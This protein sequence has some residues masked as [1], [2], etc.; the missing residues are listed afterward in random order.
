MHLQSRSIFQAAM[1]VC[2]NVTC[3][4]R[5]AGTV[6]LQGSNISHQTGKGKSST[7]ICQTSGGHVSSL[8]GNPRVF[9]AAPPF[10]H[11]SYQKARLAPQTDGHIATSGRWKSVPQGYLKRQR[12]SWYHGKSRNQLWLRRYTTLNCWLLGNFHFLA[13]MIWKM[14]SEL[15]KGYG[16]SVFQVLHRSPVIFQ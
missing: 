13:V 5:I 7:Q 16:T 15:W 11:P 2:R 3:W 12:R 6:T 4:P 9:H 14:S 10:F 1:L 8:E